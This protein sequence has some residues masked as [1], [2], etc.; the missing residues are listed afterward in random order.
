MLTNKYSKIYFA[1]TSNAKQR[2][3]EGYTTT[4]LK[5]RMA[6][7]WKKNKSIYK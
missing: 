3:T 5:S 6:I 7:G 4:I 1:I 2:I